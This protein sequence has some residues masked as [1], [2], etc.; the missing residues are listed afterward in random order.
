MKISEL[1]QILGRPMFNIGDRIKIKETGQVG[2]V[3]HINLSHGLYKAYHYMVVDENDN[4][5]SHGLHLHN[6]GFFADEIEE[7]VVV[8]ILAN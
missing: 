3:S 6:G 2:W 5:I 8:E 4:Y 1:H 7:N